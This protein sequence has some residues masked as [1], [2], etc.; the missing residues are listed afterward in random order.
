MK[1]FAIAIFAV[2]YL[3]VSSGF[4]VQIHY[5]MNK[6]AGWDLFHS[7]KGTCSGCG[8]HKAH[9]GCC[10]DE[11]KV[12]KIANDQKLTDN[13]YN[14][15]QQLS[16]NV[17]TP[18]FIDHSFVSSQ[19]ERIELFSLPPPYLRTIPVFI[20]TCNFRIWFISFLFEPDNS[21]LAIG[22]SLGLILINKLHKWFRN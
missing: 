12:V 6:L 1:K 18:S 9:S 16:L 4:T 5:C 21:C 8:M 20:R 10:K 15:I 17:V 2:F 3:A 22:I 11:Q 14:Q 19:I 7:A 13:N